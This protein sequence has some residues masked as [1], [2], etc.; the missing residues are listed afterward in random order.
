MVA[1]I[2]ARDN[3]RVPGT[4]RE[5][6]PEADPASRTYDVRVTLADEAKAAQ[7]GMTARIYLAG[8]A[9][10][11]VLL[12]PLTALHRQGDE[13]AVW[14]YE[15]KS[16]QVHL[17]PVESRPLSRGRRH[18]AGGPRARPVGRHRRRAQAGRGPDGAAGRR[19]QPPAQDVIPALRAAAGFRT[20][21]PPERPPGVLRDLPLPMNVP[22]ALSF[23]P[24]E[25]GLPRT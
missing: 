13:P 10:A 2:W 4:V 3:L 5:I 14:L 8:E 11:D 23:S 19:E 6:S 12:L 9:Q 20:V 16:G 25:K 24:R 1:E 22:R 15:P 17:K 7:L 18:R 21:P